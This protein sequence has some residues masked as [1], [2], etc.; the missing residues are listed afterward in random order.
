MLPNACGIYVG[1]GVGYNAYS[2]NCAHR[3]ARMYVDNSVV[4]HGSYS[5]WRHPASG[6]YVR[7]GVGYHI[8]SVVQ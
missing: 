8:Y 4:S 1:D 7:D 3:I 6:V 5:V 2:S